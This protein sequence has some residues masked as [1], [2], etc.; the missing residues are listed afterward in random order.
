MWLCKKANTAK[1][2]VSQTV[3]TGDREMLRIDKTEHI[4]EW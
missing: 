4:P 1:E 2:G 3:S